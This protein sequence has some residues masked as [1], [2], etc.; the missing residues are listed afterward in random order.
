MALLEKVALDYLLALLTDGRAETVPLPIREIAFQKL[1]K[2]EKRL[3]AQVEAAQAAREAAEARAGDVRRGG[4]AE[5][6]GVGEARAAAGEPAPQTAA[7]PEAGAAGDTG[8]AGAQLAGYAITSYPDVPRRLR[9]L[10]SLVSQPLRPIRRDRMAGFLGYFETKCRRS[11]AL[12]DEAKEII[13]GGVQHNLAFNYPFPIAIEKADGAYLW[14]VDGNRYID[15]LQA[16]G[17]TVLGSNYAPVREKVIE[18]LEHV[19][20]GHRPVPRIRAEA[21]A[22][23]QPAHALDRDVPHAG[24]GHRGGD[25]GHPR[26]ARLHRQES[27]SS[28]SAAR[29]TAGATRWST[30]CTSPAPAG[31]R[32]RAS[33]AAPPAHTQEFFPNDLDALRRA[34]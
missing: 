20:P 7:A 15:F 1:R 23:G 9:R 26:G 19:R 31:W 22:A 6:I 21:G 14:D 32:R 3:A 2:D 34:S 29:T 12:T 18:M 11:K 30:A 25:G 8:V 4:A 16:G 13:P 10:D 27:G 33:R 17:P 28:R 24:L 5:Q